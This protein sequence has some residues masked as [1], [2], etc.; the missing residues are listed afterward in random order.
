M[1][2]EGAA[3]E[4]SKEKHPK[5]TAPRRHRSSSWPTCQLL[6]F[7]PSFYEREN[8]DKAGCEVEIPTDGKGITVLPKVKVGSM[9]FLSYYCTS[10]P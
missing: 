6:L 1:E 4:G 8:A 9:S 3:G 7:S 10:D 5:D 2:E